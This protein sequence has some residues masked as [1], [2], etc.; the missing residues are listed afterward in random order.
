MWNLLC[1]CKS[2][3]MG[4]WCF[5]AAG[6][7]SRTKANEGEPC[8]FTKAKS[9]RQLAQHLLSPPLHHCDIGLH[10][11]RLPHSIHHPTMRCQGRQ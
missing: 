6:E 8:L 5:P 10:V 4:L 1:H 9:S 3:I 11:Y 2:G 7:P